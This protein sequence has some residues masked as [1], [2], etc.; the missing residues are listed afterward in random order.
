MEKGPKHR[1]VARAYAGML[2]AV[3][4]RPRKAA[5]LHKVEVGQVDRWLSG[6]DQV[7]VSAILDVYAYASGEV[8]RQTSLT[9]D[10]AMKMTGLSQSALC[11]FI[12]VSKG[13]ATRWR[14]AGKIPVKYAKLVV[15]SARKGN[16]D[17]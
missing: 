5:N 1:G 16:W 8:R 15:E 14:K 9:V 3:G 2:H 10:E 12:G 11:R 6:H 17:E 4:M 7:P 13:L